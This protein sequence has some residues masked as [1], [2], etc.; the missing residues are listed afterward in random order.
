MAVGPFPLAGGK[1]HRSAATPKALQARRLSH[2]AIRSRQACDQQR[3]GEQARSVPGNATNSRFGL[4][5]YPAMSLAKARE[6]WRNSRERVQAGKSPRV[7][8]RHRTA[9]ENVVGDWLR[10]DQASNASCDEVKRAIEKNVLPEW[11]GRP[12][13]P[14]QQFCSLVGHDSLRVNHARPGNVRPRSSVHVTRCRPTV[15]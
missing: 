15:P 4:H 14:G 9:V 12:S 6:A 10:L 2:R 3:E 5:G 8:S 7:P 11:R 13:D 1:C